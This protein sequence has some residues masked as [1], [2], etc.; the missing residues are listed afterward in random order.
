MRLGNQLTI[1]LV[2]VSVVLIVGIFY[3]FHYRPSEIYKYCN[4]K[5][6]K[7][8]DWDIY[9]DEDIY[10]NEYRFCLREKGLK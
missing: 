9:S 3:W 10:E 2:L 7:N 6:G 5:A 8:V 1:Y 4:W